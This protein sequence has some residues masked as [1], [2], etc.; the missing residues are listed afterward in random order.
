MQRLRLGLV[1]VNTVIS[2]TQHSSR[3]GVK[4]H[5]KQ[6]LHSFLGWLS[7]LATHASSFSTLHS[8]P[9]G[10]RFLLHS[11][12]RGA[13]LASSRRSCTQHSHKGQYMRH[14]DHAE[15]D[16]AADAAWSQACQDK[17][18]KLTGFAQDQSLGQLGSSRG[19]HCSSR[20]RNGV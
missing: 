20:Q 13:L 8:T 15:S 16:I 3:A 18:P 17:Q 4:Q 7:I 2:L 5:S 11:S 12:G 14:T 10:R 6:A 1:S 19:K 9:A